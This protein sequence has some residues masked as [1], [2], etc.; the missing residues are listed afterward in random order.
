MKPHTRRN[1]GDSGLECSFAVSIRLYMEVQGNLLG[2][3]STN[4]SVEVT[5]RLS[6]EQVLLLGHNEEDPGVCTV[7][8]LPHL[9]VLL[10]YRII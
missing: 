3:C 6:I 8:G 1:R 9:L 2:L 10:L 4:N 5:R 7:I